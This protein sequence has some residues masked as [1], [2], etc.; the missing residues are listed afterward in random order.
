VQI[1]LHHPNN[2][3]TRSQALVGLRGIATQWQHQIP[4]TA[5]FRLTDLSTLRT[6]PGGEWAARAIVEDERLGFQITP[7]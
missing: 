4:E 7:A 1:E 2:L 3:C 5:A 6:A